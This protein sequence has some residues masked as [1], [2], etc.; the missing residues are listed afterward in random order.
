MRFLMKRWLSGALTA[1]L[2]LPMAPALGEEPPKFPEEER[3]LLYGAFRVVEWSGERTWRDFDKIPF[4]V[5]LVTPEYEFLVRHPKP[6]SD[7]TAG[8]K[9]V[10]LESRV[11]F[12][13]RVFD[14]GLQ[15]SFPINGVPTVVIGQA[16]AKNVRDRARWILTLIHEHFHQLQDSQKN[17][18]ADYLALGLARGDETGMWMLNYP[19]P[20]DNEEVN[21]R[22]SAMCQALLEALKVDVKKQKKHFRFKVIEY[23]KARQ[24]FHL[25]L[26]EDDYKY[27][28]FQLWKEGVARYVEMEAGLNHAFWGRLSSVLVGG[29][30]S[31][32][33]LM[34]G[35]YESM[36]KAA[37]EIYGDSISKLSELS[38]KERQR[39][40]FYSLGAAEAILLSR[41]NPKWEGQ[42]FKK[43]FFLEEYYPGWAKKGARK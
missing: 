23:L 5:L 21:Q 18:F 37:L 29:R 39:I 13:R 19:F 20:Y 14:P 41:A 40:A 27:F 33:D 38:L 1:A 2:L 42:Y 8:P 12:R 15:A 4:A 30:G 3:W 25:V 32:G 17:A 10:W 22:F 34:Y 35:D 36:G 7:F 26:G 16:G 24:R 9:D 28:S 11:H 31:F 6:P 43:K